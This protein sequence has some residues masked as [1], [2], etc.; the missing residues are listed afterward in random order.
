MLEAFLRIL[1]RVVGN[2]YSVIG[3]EGELQDLLVQSEG[4]IQVS[5]LLLELVVFLL[6]VLN[7]C[8][9]AIRHELAYLL[10]QYIQHRLIHFNILISLRL[11]IFRGWSSDAI[12]NWRSSSCWGNTL[13]VEFEEF[14]EDC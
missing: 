7:F 4:A 2:V 8:I 3:V 6:K 10:T 13:S 5:D 1:S 11:L 9:L 12:S 14:W